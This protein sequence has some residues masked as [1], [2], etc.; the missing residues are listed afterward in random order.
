[1]QDLFDWDPLRMPSVLT[2]TDT[3]SYWIKMRDDAREELRLGAHVTRRRDAETIVTD[4]TC[5][6]EQLRASQRKVIY[7]FIHSF[8]EIHTII[9]LFDLIRFY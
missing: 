9:D 8:S 6:E 5:V 3:A 7:L 4:L 2:L 1:M